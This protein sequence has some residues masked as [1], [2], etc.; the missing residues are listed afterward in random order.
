MKGNKHGV[1]CPSWISSHMRQTKSW[2]CSPSR[3]K[4]GEFVTNSLIQVKGVAES[5]QSGNPTTENFVSS[6]QQKWRSSS[7]SSLRSCCWSSYSWSRSCCCCSQSCCNWSRS[8]CCTSPIPD[9]GLSNT[10]RSIAVQNRLPK[11]YC[12]CIPRFAEHSKIRATKSEG[13]N[14]SS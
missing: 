12:G 13:Q 10:Y 5:R 3:S 9:T 2:R 6:E 11:G 1:L 8:C 4:I 7:K 14:A